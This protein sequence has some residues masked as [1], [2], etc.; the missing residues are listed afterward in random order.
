[1]QIGLPPRSL[2]LMFSENLERTS[3]TP[4]A[5]GAFKRA[6]ASNGNGKKILSTNRHREISEICDNTACA[7]TKL[8]QQNVRR[9]DTHLS[10]RP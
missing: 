9:V 6:T 3:S 8:V 1:M 7:S 5:S 10:N 4:N 2:V